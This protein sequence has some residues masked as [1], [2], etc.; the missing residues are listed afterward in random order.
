MFSNEW[1]V[2][3]ATVVAGVLAYF[4]IVAIP[5]MVLFVFMILDYLTGL[6]AAWCIVNCRVEQDLSA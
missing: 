3:C 4:R 1:K 5:I 6:A 2:I